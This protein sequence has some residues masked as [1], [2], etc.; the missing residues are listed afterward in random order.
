VTGGAADAAAFA[1]EQARLAHLAAV[2]DASSD[3]I[4]SK[5]L[6]GVITSWNASAE[7]IFGYSS[8][9]IVGRNI[10]LLIPADRQAEEDDILANLRAGRYIEH[11]E[12][13]RLRKDGTRLDVSLSISPVK[14]SDGTIVGASKIARDITARKRA[15]EALA[16]ANAKFESVFNQ[17]GIFA[18]IMDLDGNLIEINE[19]AVE[20][21]GYTREG[22]LG[23]PFWETPW[24]RGSEEAQDRIRAATSR[25]LEGDVFRETLRYWLADG[26]ERLVDFGMHPIRDAFGVVRFLHPTGIDITEREQ[27]EQRFRS[28]VSIVT[29]VPWTADAEGR[30]IEPQPSWESFT[31]QSWEEHRGLGWLDAVYP[32]D[33]DPVRA[34]WADAAERGGLFQATGR[35]WHASTGEHRHVAARATALRRADGSIDEWVGTCTDIH[36]RTLADEALRAQEAEER[37]IA[38]GLQRALLPGQLVSNPR[39]ALAA[40]YEAGS[41]VLEVGGDWYDAFSLPDGRVG[42]TVGDVVGHGLV[43]AAAMGQLRTAVS[44]LAQ[45]SASP[46]ALLSRLDG[47]LARTQTTDFATVCYA[48]LD[49]ATGEIEYASAGHPPMLVVSPEGATSW[50]D[51]AQSPPLT[52][53]AGGLRRDRSAR[54]EPGSL[55]VLYSDG[56]IERRGERPSVGLARLAEAALGVDT[57][58]DDDV[59]VLAVRLLPSAARAFHRVFAGNPEELRGLRSAMRQWMD[60]QEVTEPVRH[61][62][63]LAVGEACANAVEHAYGDN[64]AGNVHV[65]I[66]ED[67]DRSFAVSV[68]DFGRFRERSSSSEDRGRGTDIMRTLTTDFSRDCTPSGTTVRFRLPMDALTRA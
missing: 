10:R 34:A 42:L 63:L 15:D 35:L 12:T 24:W 64:G 60:E 6:D 45:H 62:L 22:V 23:R 19:L 61:S 59:A 9:E 65:D 1:E 7:R 13:V 31:G 21:C 39:L 28:L 56:L 14:G 30:F 38:I 29:D 4:L 46:G 8:D 26:T 32:D 67:A 43:A 5:T 68:R 36:E 52:G 41:D 18:G 66:V 50:L 54:L 57:S 17:S 55:L 53:L 20:W 11:Y 33:R 47:F 40:R 58:R 49:P 44:A 16:A 27:A 48:V 2:I 37:E 51:G 25:A 3:A